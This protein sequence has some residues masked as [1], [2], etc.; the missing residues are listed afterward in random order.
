MSADD[1]VNLDRLLRGKEHDHGGLGTILAH[2]VFS[3]PEGGPGAEFI[4]IAVL[5]PGTSIGRHRHGRDRETYI[6]LSGSGLMHRDGTEF[7]VV[8]GDVVVNRPYGEHGLVNDSAADLW[9][10]VFEEELRDRPTV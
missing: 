3:R 6:V 8:A 7:R 10:L 5:P 1:V 4:D 9:L 2:R